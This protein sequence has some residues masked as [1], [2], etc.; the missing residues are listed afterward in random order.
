MEGSKGGREAGREEGGKEGKN[1]G[2]KEGSEEARKN[3]H[4]GLQVHVT[5]KQSTRLLACWACC[6]YMMSVWSGLTRDA[7]RFYV[8]LLVGR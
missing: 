8:S 3:M 2:S 1:G 6:S 5:V 7:L 4:A